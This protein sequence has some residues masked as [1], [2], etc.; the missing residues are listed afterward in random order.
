MAS[1][2]SVRN[3]LFLGFDHGLLDEE[4]FLLMYEAYSSENPTYPYKDYLRFDLEL[5][6]DVECKTEFRVEKKD[7]PELVH[8][9]RIPETVKCYQGTICEAEE[10]LCILLKRFTYPCRYSDLIP[11]F[12]RPVP[13]LAMITN[14]MVNY[15]Y[16]IH[17]HRLTQW[18]H[19]ILQP[20]ALETYAQAITNKGAALTNCFGFVDGTVRQI[21]RPGKNQRMVYN[22]HK[23][24]HA[25]KF[26]SVAIPNGIIANLYG[27]VGK[28]LPSTNF[29][30]LKPLVSK[31][32][33]T[34][35]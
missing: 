7:I 11:C 13:E 5:K 24:V 20:E 14:E 16:D 28:N 3:L 26:Q 30:G 9:L 32:L 10:A 15:I 25:L 31:F 1:F 18:N 33:K 4:E 19:Q 29:L 21:S 23:R 2:E 6:D 12:G 17:G 27:P 35:K 8:A 34:I 22:G